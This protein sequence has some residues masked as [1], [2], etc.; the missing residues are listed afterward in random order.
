MGK[1]DPDG[2]GRP[3]VASIRARLVAL[4]EAM[5]DRRLG[6]G[7]GAAESRAAS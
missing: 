7:P 1:V 4:E 3:F 5:P 2:G 6:V